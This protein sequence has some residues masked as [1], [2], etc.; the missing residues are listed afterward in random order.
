M[1]TYGNQQ[2]IGEWLLVW[3][4]E[5]DFLRNVSTYHL[6]RECWLC[7]SRLSGINSL[8]TH[9]TTRHSD[10]DQY[11]CTRCGEGFAL[12]LDA[13]RHKTGYCTGAEI[14]RVYLYSKI[15]Q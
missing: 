12:H 9:W 13:T 3:D 14:E 2:Y 8:K 15:V 4:P 7:K 11:R 5:S 1:G 10:V 6:P